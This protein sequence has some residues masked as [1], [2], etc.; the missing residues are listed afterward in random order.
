MQWDLAIA[1]KEI[2]QKNFS[3]SFLV[4]GETGLQYQPQM[5]G[6]ECWSS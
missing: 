1:A 3:Y 5:I 4:W 2:I 6:D